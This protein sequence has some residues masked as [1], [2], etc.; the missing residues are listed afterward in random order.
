MPAQ[1]LAAAAA[2]PLRW[3]RLPGTQLETGV[4]IAV[5]PV[6]AVPVSRHVDPAAAPAELTLLGTLD[7]NRRSFSQAAPGSELSTLPQRRGCGRTLNEGIKTRRAWLRVG[8]GSGCGEGWWGAWGGN[9][10]EGTK[11][12]WHPHRP[13]RVRA[14]AVARG[15]QAGRR[16]RQRSVTVCTGCCS[17]QCP[18]R[19][20]SLQ[21]SAQPN[22]SLGRWSHRVRV[23]R[24]H[25]GCDPSRGD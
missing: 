12:G 23:G 13:G 22:P 19:H 21:G 20:W 5:W 14:G 11:G 10:L 24:L 6:R 15:W 2:A 8:G 3:L 1:P 9:G 25:V 16:A 18:P 17:R 7:P 4:M